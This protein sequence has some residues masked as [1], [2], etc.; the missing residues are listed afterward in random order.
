MLLEEESKELKIKYI[1]NFNDQVMQDFQ[2]MIDK[3]TLHLQEISTRKPPEWTELKN[4]KCPNCPLDEKEYQHCPL[5]KNLSAVLTF[6]NALPSFHEALVT[7][8][9]NE[10]IS[11]KRTTVQIGVGS[12]IGIIMSTSGC[13][14]VGKLRSLVR[15]HLPFSSLEETEYRVISMYILAQHFKAIR[16][17]QPDWKLEK[18]KSAY[19]QIQIVN[20]NIVE[21]LSDVELNDTTR[22][23][24]VTLSNFAEYILMN[25]EDN[26][27]YHLQKYMKG[28]EE[29]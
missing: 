20:R 21:K 15:F 25:L 14:V 17:E 23:A 16:N 7:V 4:F 28:F 19:K 24:V 5:A 9:T 27:F 11:Q 10:R 3:E 12:L 2:I 29:L 26:E 8:E 6:F 18:L 13:P 22:N 1:F